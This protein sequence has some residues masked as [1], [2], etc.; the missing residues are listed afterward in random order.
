MDMIDPNA[1]S[2]SA[3]S[4]QY[5]A[6]TGNLA[7]ANT[8]AYKRRMTAFSQELANQMSATSNQLPMTT[9]SGRTALDLTPGALV[10][11]ENPLSVAIGGKGFFAIQTPE[12]ELYTRDGNFRLN[13]QSQLVD[14]AGRMV[15]GSGGPIIV[16]PQVNPENITIGGDGTVS[17]NGQSLGQIK[18][19]EFANTGNLTPIG[20]GC[21]RAEGETPTAAK[22]PSLAQGFR[23]ASNV[24]VV[25]ELVGLITVTRLYEA[26]LKSIQSQDERTKSLLQVAMS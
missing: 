14:A 9:V 19:V 25:E 5:L 18:V 8:D 3:L 10:K 1:S 11:C 22:A 2:L 16:P 17:V 15:A 7:N 13:N 21:Y 24:N 6:I 12:G 4:Q 26:N 23:E 20:G